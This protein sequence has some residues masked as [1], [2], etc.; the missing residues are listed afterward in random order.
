MAHGNAFARADA[1]FASGEAVVAQGWIDNAKAK[2]LGRGDCLDVGVAWERVGVGKRG[3]MSSLLGMGIREGWG[4]RT[5][6]FNSKEDTDLAGVN[7]DGADADE[8]ED[9]ITVAALEGDD[10]NAGTI[11]LFSDN[12]ATMLVQ[13]L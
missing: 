3:R 12:L 11:S 1:E 4:G 9:T 13:R 2:V 10:A 5:R 7:F 8:H 6:T